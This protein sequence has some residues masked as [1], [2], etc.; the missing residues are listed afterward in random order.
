MKCNHAKEFLSAYIDDVLDQ[1]ARKN[2]E[3]HLNS[4]RKCTEELFALRKYISEVGSLRQVKAPDDFVEKV[5]ERIKRRF[6]FE[7]MMRS[8]F[9]PAR[10]KIPLE[11]AGLVLT[12]LLVVITY[13][14]IEPGIN[15]NPVK[16]NTGFI[17]SLSPKTAEVQSLAI[18]QEPDP[19][20]GSQ[21][22]ALPQKDQEMI[23][24]RTATQSEPSAKN[25]GPLAMAGAGRFYDLFIRI[26]E[27]DLTLDDA[28]YKAN[29]I[30]K[31]ESATVIF[32]KTAQDGQSR[33]ILLS[34]PARNYE[35]LINKMKLVGQ[36]R[37]Q[38]VSFGTDSNEL[39]NLRVHLI[40]P[41]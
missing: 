24:L 23:A 22:E 9:I 2:L 1:P 18:N 30:A 33:I 13:R 11:A 10:I 20:I 28:S 14:I 17:E 39:L 4:C 5:N 25:A 27:K 26:V 8:L 31:S 19:K 34:V 35:S 37:Y 29:R 3:Q 32:M 6:E 41:Q 15:H 36:I 12:V 40:L 16:R 21:Q 7:N 38:P